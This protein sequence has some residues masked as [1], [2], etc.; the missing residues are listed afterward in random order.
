[1]LI[2][3]CSHVPSRLKGIETQGSRPLCKDEFC[4]SHVPSRLKGIETPIDRTTF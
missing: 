3:I 2:C 1:M 4:R